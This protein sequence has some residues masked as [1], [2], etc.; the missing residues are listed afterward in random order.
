MDLNKLTEKS[1]AALQAA[2]AIA[3]QNSNN[4]LD[5]EHLLAALLRQEQGLVPSLLKKAGVPLDTFSLRLTQEIDKLPKV[6]GSSGSPDQVYVTTRIT[7]IVA[8]AEAE[9]NRMKDHFVSVEHL[10]LAFTTD[11]GPAGKPG[12]GFGLTRARLEAALKDLR[13]PRRLT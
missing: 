13:V 1:Q 2:Q 10:L 9:A 5:A 4:Q 12:K 7:K 8:D 11:N 6:A 3:V